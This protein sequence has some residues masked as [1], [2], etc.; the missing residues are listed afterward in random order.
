MKNQK[1]S[2]ED[3]IEPSTEETPSKFVIIYE[4]ISGTFE[5]LFG[6]GVL[7][8]GKQIIGFYMNLKAKEILE[9]PDDLLIRFTQVLIPTIYDYKTYIALFFVVLGIVKLTSGIGLIYKKVWANHLL[10]GLLTILIPFD[11]IGVIAN[12]SYI[13]LINLI[14]D[15]LLI[16]FLVRFRPI[17]YYR[18]LRKIFQ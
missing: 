11:F 10:V 14:L 13:K 12:F 6:A 17:D 15:A 18:K 4:L 5:F 3:N 16:L 8:F 2:E 7:L 9:D 1:S